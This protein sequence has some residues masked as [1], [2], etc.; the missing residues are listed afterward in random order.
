MSY[1][2][3]V[4]DSSGRTVFNST[5]PTE[6]TIWS[7]EITTATQASAYGGGGV[8][9][10]K[11]IP[12][13]CFGFDNAVFGTTV[14]RATLA[15]TP[16]PTT[17]A[18]GWYGGINYTGTLKDYQII[19]P[20]V[21]AADQAARQYSRLK[22]GYLFS[23]FESGQ[24]YAIH[25][26]GYTFD[27]QYAYTVWNMSSD[28]STINSTVLNTEVTPVTTKDTTPTIWVR[29]KSSSFQGQ[30]GTMVG[31]FVRGYGLISLAASSP[32][33]TVP[34][35]TTAT[36]NLRYNR[37]L[38]MFTDQT[39]S[40]IFEVK[41]TV[42]ASDWGTALSSRTLKYDAGGASTYALESYTAGGFQHHSASTAEQ[43]TTFSTLTRPAK[44]Y[45]AVGLVP[46]S[47]SGNTSTTMIN[48][49]NNSTYDTN[50]NYCR[51]NGSAVFKNYSTGSLKHAYTYQY[52]W[53]ANRSIASV[54]K[55]YNY[56]G[57]GNTHSPNIL[58]DTYG[59][60]QLYAIAEFGEPK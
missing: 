7:G 28:V 13:Y 45:S 57:V 24:V 56:V 46:H 22:Y 21:S 52:Q 17:P 60:K 23:Y 10:H 25:S 41:L 16:T 5:H 48:V 32:R 39:G 11:P 58:F 50:K 20:Y 37:G 26:Q 19:M 9:D 31:D 34:V 15:S 35:S 4:F 30:F 49:A 43:W 33:Y 18:A 54:W 29:P 38:M 36:D 1:G 12:D 14:T 2:I 6:L 47:S 42:P 55:K 40:N 8:S 59:S 3:E 27:Y 53:W 51:M 44:V